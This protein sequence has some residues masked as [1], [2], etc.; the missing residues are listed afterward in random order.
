MKTRMVVLLSSDAT[1]TLVSDDLF[2]RVENGIAGP[3]SQKGS[4]LRIN[5]Y[6]IKPGH[7]IADWAKLETEGWRPYAEAV[8]KETPGVGWRASA[9]L[10]P[11]GASPHY[12]AMTIDIF[13]NWTAAGR[14]N[15]LAMWSKVHPEMSA[16][17]YLSKVNEVV[18]RY[19]AELYTVMEYGRK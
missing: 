12:N 13:P 10:M 18:D 16:S 7:S 9:L 17:D 19:K 5:L 3:S 2:R 15:S 11:G 4:Y 14:G 8:A 6:K 1:S